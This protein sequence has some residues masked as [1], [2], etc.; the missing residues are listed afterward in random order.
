MRLTSLRR[1]R[2]PDLTGISGPARLDRRTRSIVK[3]IR[4]GDIAVIDHVDIDRAAAVALVEAGAV[5]VVNLAPSVSGRYPNLGPEVLVEA[6]VVLVDNVD[7]EVFSAIADGEMIRVH[8]ADIYKGDQHLGS[9]TRQDADSV[10]ASLEVSKVAMASRLDAFS[11]N[12]ME[13]L[14]RERALLLDGEGVPDL[15]TSLA[16]RHVI[17]VRRA[18]DYLRDLESLRT[19]I[20]ENAPVLVGVDAGADVL[21]EAGYRPDII[22]TD[23]EEVTDTALQCA[24]EVVVPAGEDRRVKG[25]DRLERLGVDHTTF[26]TGGTSEDSA[27]LLA[28]AHHARLIVLAGSHS[29][30][31]EFLDIG[32]SG[33]AS[34]FLT[35]AAAGSRLV[36]ARAVA[37][38]YSNRIRTWLALLLMLVGVAL[39]AAA[40][41]TTPVGQD[42]WDQLTKGFG[43]LDSWVRDKVG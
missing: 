24:A 35:R 12:A 37:Q 3:R 36:D 18:F 20:R 8:G 30:L 33:M 31:R 21:L 27:I 38:L 1:G 26:T 13:H 17:I 22:V 9:G 41:A 42:W 29:S 7:S 16:D 6:G 10:S 19:Y 4:P 32:R 5:A 2:A 25:L 23:L 15:G 28:H 40:I 11:A 39:V 43:E 34:S 14:R